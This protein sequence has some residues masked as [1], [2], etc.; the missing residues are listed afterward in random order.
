[1]NLSTPDIE[2]FYKL[3]GSLL[4]YANRELKL[5]AE[6]IAAGSGAQA[7]DREGRQAA[8]CLLRQARNPEAVSGREPRPAPR[9]MSWR[10]P[11]AG[12]S[13]S[14]AISTSCDI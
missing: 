6:G 14:R 7:A 1:M 5:L 10:S 4:A 13:G 11:P 9:R 12:S 3:H 8:R 2:L